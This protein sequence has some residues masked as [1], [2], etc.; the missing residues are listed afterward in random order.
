[1]DALDYTGTWWLDQA[2]GEGRLWRANTP[3]K[4]V[5]ELSTSP[6]KAEAARWWDAW[7]DAQDQRNLEEEGIPLPTIRTRNFD[8]DTWR[9]VRC[10]TGREAGG[11]GPGE[12]TGSRVSTGK[13]GQGA[14]S[15]W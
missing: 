9:L 4:N 7:R 3:N 13:C 1:M 2:S 5:R 12:G 11:T 8:D 14:E 15:V 10:C 6:H